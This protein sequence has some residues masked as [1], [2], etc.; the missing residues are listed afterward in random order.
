M[1]YGYEEMPFHIGTES[2]SARS[3]RP[4]SDVWRAWCGMGE[5]GRDRGR[6]GCRVVDARRCDGVVGDASCTLACDGPPGRSNVKEG[7]PIEIDVFSGW[8]GVVGRDGFGR[9]EP[10]WDGRGR[11]RDGDGNAGWGHRRGMGTSK[12]YGPA[13]VPVSV[14]PRGEL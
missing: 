11:R 6:R 9:L 8:N 13:G 1:S 7:L 5:H 10:P 3:Y 2:P 4:R 12:V 14:P